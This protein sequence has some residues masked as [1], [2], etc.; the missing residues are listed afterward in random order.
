MIW[1]C[2]SSNVL[3]DET[4]ERKLNNNY[5]VTK[6]GGLRTPSLIQI[7]INFSNVRIILMVMKQYS[8]AV[9][10]AC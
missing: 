4:I 3:Y 1:H 8:W 6:T 7:D 10:F 5:N 2:H 9:T